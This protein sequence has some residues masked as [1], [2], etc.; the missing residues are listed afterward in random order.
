[1]L[2]FLKNDSRQTSD[3]QWLTVWTPNLWLRYRHSRC[4]SVRLWKKL[5]VPPGPCSGR[6]WLLTAKKRI[7]GKTERING[8]QLTHV[9]LMQRDCCWDTSGG[10]VRERLRFCTAERP[11]RWLRQV[12]TQMQ[13]HKILMV[14]LQITFFPELNYRMIQN[15]VSVCN[16]SDWSLVLGIQKKPSSRPWFKRALPD[17]VNQLAPSV[18]KQTKS[19]EPKKR[20]QLKKGQYE[21]T[22]KTHTQ[23]H[24]LTRT[25]VSTHTHD[26]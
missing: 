5:L 2:S 21:R 7:V 24:T 16:D 10:A 13:Q 9:T 1:M 3:V 15:R 22:I 8:A 19:C 18:Q 20:R 25:H 23:T 14:P 6:P 17:A 12:N 11:N 26:R 4:P